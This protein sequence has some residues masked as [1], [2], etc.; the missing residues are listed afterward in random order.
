MEIAN[1]N[2]VD[3]LLRT[4]PAPFPPFVISPFALPPPARQTM[5]PFSVARRL[6]FS[7]LETD[8]ETDEE[9]EAETTRPVS[10]TPPSFVSR[11]VSSPTPAESVTPPPQLINLV[12]ETFIC[13]DLTGTTEDNPIVI[14]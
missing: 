6:N 5:N 14:E 4:P 8:L 2:D 7:D 1:S 12:S 11:L 9:L 13:V 10:P 3:W